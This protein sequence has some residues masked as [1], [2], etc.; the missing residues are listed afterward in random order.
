MLQNLSACRMSSCI[1]AINAVTP[2]QDNDANMRIKRVHE[3]RAW[4]ICM[5][6]V[7]VWKAVETRELIEQ[8]SALLQHQQTCP[9]NTSHWT[10]H[11]IV[12]QSPDRAHH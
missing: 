8:R 12:H 4:D 3:T 11:C 9:L 5:Q 6:S 7:A 1:M 2:P 10:H